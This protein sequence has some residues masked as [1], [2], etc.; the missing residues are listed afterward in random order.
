MNRARP[1]R[2]TSPR[3]GVTRKKPEQLL[4]GT[5]VL[6]TLRQELTRINI[7]PGQ[8]LI[9]DMDDITGALSV[10][11]IV[12]STVYLYEPGKTYKNDIAR[13]G[14]TRKKA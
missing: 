6:G 10:N 12:N 5:Y 11:G 7:Q 4:P 3:F 2:T 8:D 9:V 13:F 14:A 1:I